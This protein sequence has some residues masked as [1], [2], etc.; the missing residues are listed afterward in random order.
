MMQMMNRQMVNRRGAL[1]ALA[2]SFGLGMVTSGLGQS[3]TWLGTYDRYAEAHGVSADGTVVV[4]WAGVTAT[5]IAFRWTPNPGWQNI[6][7]PTGSDTEAWGLSADGQVIVG[8]TSIGGGVYRGFRWRNGTFTLFGTFGGPTSWAWAANRD[9]SVIVGAAE[10]SNGFNRAFRWTQATGMVNLGTLPGGIRSVARGVSLDGDVV[11]GWSGDGSGI[12]HAWR[13]EN[14]TMTDIHNPA[15][16]QSEAIGVSGN[17]QVVVGAWGPPSF[18][19]A[20]PF[21]WTSETGMVDLGT[22]G[23][24][25]GEAWAANED[26]GIVV[27]W[28]EVAQGNWHAFRW[29]EAGGMED[30]NITYASLLT[31]GSVLRWASAISPDGRYIAGNGTRPDG[32]YYAFLLDTG[33][34]CTAHSGDV[35]NNGCIDDA[36][37]LAVLFA[38]G[39]TGSNLGRVDV[40][41][42]GIVDD[43]DLLQVLFNFG[44]GC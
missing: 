23:G 22:L 42:D 3:L 8:V 39:N 38:F 25:W 32:R 17:G 26:G 36:D 15:F 6:G 41:C 30:L 1:C 21:R 28:S 9:G 7:S 35:D 44:N 10:L 27:G 4:G 24:A 29:T 2:L 14:G 31:D 43:A 37:L 34:R 20:R 13:W 40:N 18:T 19:P 5:H 16:G 12:H 33:P 11:V